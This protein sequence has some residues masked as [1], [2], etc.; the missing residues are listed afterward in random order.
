MDNHFMKMKLE[1][2]QTYNYYERCETCENKIISFKKTLVNFPFKFSRLI[3]DFISTVTWLTK[4]SQ[5]CIR[6]KV[7]EA[8]I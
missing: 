5:I 8:Y 7:F 4:H 6:L 3:R 1:V 2:L